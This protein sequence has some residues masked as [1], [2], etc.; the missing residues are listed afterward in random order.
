M[1]NHPKNTSA[2]PEAVVRAVEPDDYE[3]LKTIYAQRGV[4]YGTLQM[5]FPSAQMWK[6]RIGKPPPGS[7]MLVACVDDL[8]I[9][10]IGLITNSNPRRSH[11][12]HIGM[13]VHDDFAGRGIGELLVE[14]V[15]DIA[16]NWLNLMRLEL[17][18][19]VDNHRAV[20]LYQRT[21]FEVEGTFCKYAFRDGE[22]VDALTMARLRA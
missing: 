18:V 6:E 19:F 10:N 2:Y 13:G 4:Y 21:G 11:S 9:G 22:Y 15:I 5:P 17:S 16:D 12:G 20:S 8:P 7:H 3:A 1:P 14:A